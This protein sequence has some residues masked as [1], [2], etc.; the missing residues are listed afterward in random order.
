MDADSNA[1]AD[2]GANA[3]DPS[4]RPDRRGLSSPWPILVAVGFALSEV[5]VIVGLLPIAVGGLLVLSGGAAALLRESSYASSRWRPLSAFGGALVVA[6][7]GL[8]LAGGGPLA[9]VVGFAELGGV[10][11]RGLAIALAGVIVLAGAVL[12]RARTGA[13]T[14]GSG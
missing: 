1:N 13:T 7:V 9:T 4:D 3:S 8:Y 10:A 2:T 11:S 12:E 5:G 6:G 14:S